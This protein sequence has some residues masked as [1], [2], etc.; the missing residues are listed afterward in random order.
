MSDLL[1][2]RLGPSA[3]EPLSSNS[4]GPYNLNIPEKKNQ[5]TLIHSCSP[6]VWAAMHAH[7]HSRLRVCQQLCAHAHTA[8]TP[9]FQFL[10][11]FLVWSHQ[12]DAG[13]THWALD[14]HQGL[15]R[16]PR[17]HLS[18]QRG[19]M[20]WQSISACVR[21][22]LCVHPRLSLSPSQEPHYLLMKS[23]EF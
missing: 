20:S 18:Q 8:H 4:Q 13:A 21:W 1:I 11:P 10:L 15:H 22:G 16:G 14:T 9:S 7:C 19:M 17:F 2:T 5:D 3:D 23:R 12:H 6:Q